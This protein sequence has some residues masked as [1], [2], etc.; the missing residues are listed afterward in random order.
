MEATVNKQAAIDGYAAFAAMDADAAMKDISDSV[1]WVVSGDSS[2]TGTYNGKDEVGGL[3][4]KL[5]EKGFRTTPREFIAEGDK[6]VAI[7]DT[8]LGQEQAA[9]VNV[10]TYDTDGKLIRFE[11][12]G[13][14]ELLNRTFPR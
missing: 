12:Y 4:M 8:N 9:S 11:T 3:W 1:E 2:L 5:L 14:E 13:G 7:C 6:V 10:L